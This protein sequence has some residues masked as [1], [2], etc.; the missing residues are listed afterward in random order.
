MKT[1][2]LDVGNA[3]KGKDT[4][5]VLDKTKAELIAEGVAPQS[6][7]LWDHSEQEKRKE[8]LESDKPETEK[9]ALIEKSLSHSVEVL[10]E[11]A[12]VRKKL[13]MTGVKT[14]SLQAHHSEQV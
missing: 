5:E 1:A 6:L 11:R 10:K 12:K 14:T 9:K 8:I 7:R 2:T 4:M 13:Q 3:Q